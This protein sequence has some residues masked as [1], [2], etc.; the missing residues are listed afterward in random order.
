ML[1]LKK[2]ICRPLY[3]LADLVPVRRSVQQRSQD[4][5]VQRSLEQI[6]SLLCLICHGRRSTFAAK[7]MVGIRLWIVKSFSS[8]L[9]FETAASATALTDEVAVGYH[10]GPRIDEVGSGRQ[11]HSTRLCFVGLR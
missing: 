8:T 4:E 1:H 2:I 10:L 5:H 9:F 11:A 6:P 3:V 7:T